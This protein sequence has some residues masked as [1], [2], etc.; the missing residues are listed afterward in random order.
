MMPHLAE[1]CWRVL[2]HAGM[3]ADEAWPEADA[4]LLRRDIATLAVQIGGKLRATIEL[5]RDLDEAAVREAALGDEKVRRG[6][7]GD[8]ESV[9]G[10]KSVSGRGGLGGGRS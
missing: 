4:V 8:G 7:E 2:G 6:V 1:E 5:A 3:L 10:G 9:G